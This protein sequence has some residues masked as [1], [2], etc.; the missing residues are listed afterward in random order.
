MAASII[1]S[2]WADGQMRYI[3]SRRDETVD[4]ARMNKMK[5]GNEFPNGINRHGRKVAVYRRYVY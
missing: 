3:A 4:Y 1:R 5:I 2:T